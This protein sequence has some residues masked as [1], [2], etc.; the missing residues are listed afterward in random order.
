[1]SDPNKKLQRTLDLLS[2]EIEKAL[3]GYYKDSRETIKGYLA[4]LYEKYSKDGILSYSDMTK[5][6]RLDSLN[7]FLADEMKSLGKSVGSDVKTLVGDMYN[8]AY[9]GYGQIIDEQAD[10]SLNWGIV[11]RDTISSLI[12]EPSVAG[13][14]LVEILGKAQYNNLLKMRQTLTQ[15]MIQGESYQDVARRIRDEYDKS[16]N[17]AI[18]IA[19]TE[20]TRASGEGQTAAYD[21]AEELGI[22]L[23]RIW[24]A[25][26]DA[27]TRESHLAMDGQ[28]ADEDGLFTIP[29]GYDNAGLQAEY[30][31]GFSEPSESINCRCRVIAEVK[32]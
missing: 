9:F 14:S 27:R 17:D 24:V 8:K 20:G 22:V 32:V 6:N 7:L 30:P 4:D 28:V 10:Q 31:G 23:E 25:T 3:Y 21:R 16:F 26:D 18:R 2:A 29:D 5:Y 12:N 13:L 19:R 11:N 15:S 1:M